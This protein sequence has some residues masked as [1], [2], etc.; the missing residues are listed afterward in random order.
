MKNPS[1]GYRLSNGVVMPCLGLGTW[2]MTDETAASSARCALE[3]G[4]RHIDTAAYY[5]NEAGVG[6]GIRDSGL[7]R[8]EIFLTTKLWNTERGYDKALFAFER[9]LKALKTDYVDLYLIHWPNP[10]PFREDWEQMNAETWRALEK[11]YEEGV[12]R[13]IGV[14]NFYQK[15]ILALEKSQR[16]APMVN[17]LKLCPGLPQRDICY[18]CREKGMVLS[19]YSPLGCGTAFQ[20]AP[21]TALAEKYGVSPARLVLR[22]CL[23]EGF[24]PLPKSVTPSRIQDNAR[25]FDFAISPAD[26]EAIAAMTTVGGEAPDPD[27]VPF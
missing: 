11:L 24:V 25:L 22:W 13:A 6:Q 16:I 15:H 8:Q 2:L 19:G 23:D 5:Q 10:A 20:H 12:V 4:Y 26:H 17:Q 14:S 1:D 21:L 18:F 9:S 7:P 27:T 3:C